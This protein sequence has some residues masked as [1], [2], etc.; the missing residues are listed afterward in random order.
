MD[1]E[2]GDVS[3]GIEIGLGT[4]VMLS[5]GNTVVIGAIDGMKLSRGE[6]ERVS[7]EEMDHWFWMSEG[8]KFVTSEGDEDGQIQPE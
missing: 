1:H 7:L 4:P 2:L 5:R 6:I 8:W 3:V